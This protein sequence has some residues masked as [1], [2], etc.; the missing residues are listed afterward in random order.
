MMESFYITHHYS[1]KDLRV[2]V[3]R[4]REVKWLD[5]FHNWDKWVKH[6]FQK[7]CMSTNYVCL[8]CFGYF[9]NDYTLTLLLL[10]PHVSI[11]AL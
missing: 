5:M 1:E 9:F 7:V 8:M 2:E 10:I 4:Q 11:S 6:R 3:A